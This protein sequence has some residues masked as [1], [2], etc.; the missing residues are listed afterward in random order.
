M[1]YLQ[2]FWKGKKEKSSGNAA[3]S[4][5]VTPSGQFSNHLLER[6]KKIDELKAVIPVQMLQVDIVP[7]KLKVV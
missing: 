6:F 7:M 1:Q 5:V 3:Q 4:C 2:G